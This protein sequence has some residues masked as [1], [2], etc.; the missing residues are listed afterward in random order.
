M[1]TVRYFAKYSGFYLTGAALLA[2][3]PKVALLQVLGQRKLDG[4][5]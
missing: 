5:I 4:A 2:I 1:L 3:S